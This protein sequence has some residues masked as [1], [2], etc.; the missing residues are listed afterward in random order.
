MEHSAQ[1]VGIL[2]GILWCISF[3]CTCVATGPWCWWMAAPYPCIENKMRSAVPHATN[4]QPQPQPRSPP[5]LC[6]WVGTY[7]TVPSWS[8]TVLFPVHNCAVLYYS[9]VPPPER[10]FVVFFICFILFEVCR[11]SVFH[12][13]LFPIHAWVYTVTNGDELL[14]SRHLPIF[15]LHTQVIL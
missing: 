5:A 1:W 11:Y 9:T 4:N 14:E 3:A 7:C 10:E 8:P 12:P 2:L 13:S 6:T 15:S